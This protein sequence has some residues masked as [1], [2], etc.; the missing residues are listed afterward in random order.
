MLRSLHTKLVMILILSLEERRSFRFPAAI[1]F[2]PE[3][4]MISSQIISISLS[5]W[6]LIKTVIPD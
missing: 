3:I 2:P 6:L 4:I 5:K 1:S